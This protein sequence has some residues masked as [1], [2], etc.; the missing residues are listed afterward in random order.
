MQRTKC[1]GVGGHRIVNWRQA[2]TPDLDSK[3]VVEEESAH[4]GTECRGWATLTI[5]E[6][7]Y[8][9]TPWMCP[10]LLTFFLPNVHWQ[11]SV[12]GRGKKNKTPSVTL[13]NDG[14]PH[15]NWLAADTASPPGVST[16]TSDPALEEEPLALATAERKSATCPKAKEWIMG[17]GWW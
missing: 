9:D 14:T 7:R 1:S 16:R 12:H 11:R 8:N 6:V 13:S 10:P 17:D 5:T 4:E 15:L 3:V 2:Q